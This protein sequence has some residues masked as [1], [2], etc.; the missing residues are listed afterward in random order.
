MKNMSLNLMNSIGGRGRRKQ[1]Y[2]SG[3][4]P[5]G[6]GSGRGYIGKILPT[7]FRCGELGHYITECD[8]PPRA[9]EDMF[10]LPSQLPDRSKDYAVEIKGDPGSS[11]RFTAEEKGKGKALNVIT[12]GKAK[13]KE[14]EVMPIG[15]RTTDKR[16]NI[17]VPGPSKKRGK[18]KEGDDATTKKKRR[19]RRH[20]QVSDF[21]MGVGQASYS[22]KDDIAD[23]TSN[24]TFGKIMEL[25]PKLRRQWKSL[26]N[27]TEKEPKKGSVTIMS[28]KD[29]EDICPEVEAWHKCRNLGKAYIDGGA[30]V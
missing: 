17:G 27:P 6:G 23:R 25:A 22:H 13:K 10:P 29:L 15:K 30:Q 8:K 5:S 12:L 16:D 19:P 14:A 7:C 2:A 28:V 4:G 24:I 9:G 11:N 1:F 3:D 18:A 21:P 20:F 26:A